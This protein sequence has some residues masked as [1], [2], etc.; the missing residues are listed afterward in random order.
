MPCHVEMNSYR[1][2]RIMAWFFCAEKMG[3]IERLPISRPILK[4]S[5][6]PHLKPL[7]YFFVLFHPKWMKHS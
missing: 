3:F 1:L 5:N 6:L 7:H 4:T 2:G